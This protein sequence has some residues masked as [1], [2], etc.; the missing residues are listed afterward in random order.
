[1][2]KSKNYILPLFWET[3]NALLVYFFPIFFLC[4]MVWIFFNTIKI[5]L[6]I[7]LFILFH[8]T[9]VFSY[10]LKKSIKT[11]CNSSITFFCN[12]FNHYPIFGYLEYQIFSIINAKMNNWEYKSL[13]ALFYFIYDSCLKKGIGGTYC[14]KV[15]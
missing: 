3:H 12:L 6:Y 15:F 5:I 11:F 13:F 8:L 1:M 10:I 14:Q 4:I 7:L 9:W 2:K